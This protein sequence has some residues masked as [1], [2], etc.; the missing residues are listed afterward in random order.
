MG[1]KPGNGFILR[2]LTHSRILSMH[3]FLCVNNQECA[4]IELVRE[5]FFVLTSAAHILD[6]GFF[7]ISNA[8]KNFNMILK[9]NPLL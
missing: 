6:W 5:G 9:Q 4:V 8:K 1:H 3:V 2:N 7:C